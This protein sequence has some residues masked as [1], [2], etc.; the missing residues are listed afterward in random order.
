MILYPEKWRNVRS[1]LIL[2]R[3]WAKNGVITDEQLQKILER[4]PVEYRTAPV[5]LAVGIYVLI[6][7]AIFSL[8]AFLTTFLRL[9]ENVI[10][11]SATS[12]SFGLCCY[13]FLI[14]T[15]RTRK[16]FNAGIDNAFQ[17]AF[18]A[19]VYI[20]I[21]ALAFKVNEQPAPITF[22]LAALPLLLLGAI[23]FA[24]IVFATL[25]NCCLV[26]IIFLW[27]EQHLIVPYSWIPLFV[28]G[29]SCFLYIVAKCTENLAL[30]KPWRNSLISVE[31]FAVI[32]LYAAVN[33]FLVE[34]AHV[35]YWNLEI[36]DQLIP[37]SNL[38]FIL[39]GTIP[40]V[41]IG[42]GI[43]R[44]DR[45]LIRIGI[46]TLIASAFTFQH[47]YFN[48][49]LMEFLISTGLIF[50]ITTTMAYLFLRQPKRGFINTSILQHELGNLNLDGV[51]IDKFSNVVSKERA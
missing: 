17:I 37:L 22:A 12:F 11:F 23:R 15:V 25:L 35:R 33:Y 45:L 48:E 1:I 41:Y 26:V 9:S 51:L 27:L 16:L 47:H 38:H 46:L 10:L 21:V 6:L 50:L 7:L 4:K 13:F 20:G 18:A 36:T 43:Y 49:H 30:L 28:V 8:Y 42:A 3:R 40:L 14:Y 5:L 32:M 34:E 24:S 29:W 31:A 39:T 19:I 2:S 44:R